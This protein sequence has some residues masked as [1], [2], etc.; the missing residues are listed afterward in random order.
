[1]GSVRPVR[2]SEAIPGLLAV[3]LLFLACGR[4]E[5]KEPEL[6]DRGSVVASYHVGLLVEDFGFS[7][8]GLD[9]DRLPYVF[10][11]SSDSRIVLLVYSALRCEQAPIVQVREVGNALLV[12]ITPRRAD[13]DADCEAM[14]VG[15]IVELRLKDVLDD[16]TITVSLGTASPTQR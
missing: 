14:A 8:S 10:E 5:S 9:F 6:I 11:S 2:P 1:M 4:A 15:W 3:A 7:E 12:G 16:R 13:S